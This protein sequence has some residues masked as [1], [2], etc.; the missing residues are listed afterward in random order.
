M[1][2]LAA[3]LPPS[4]RR[5]I[6]ARLVVADLRTLRFDKI[7]G[8]P[9]ELFSDSETGILGPSLIESEITSLVE[10]SSVT[11]MLNSIRLMDGPLKKVD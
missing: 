10:L 2:R 7:G 9:P 11:L 4:N 3:L 1:I 5:A 8:V 6:H